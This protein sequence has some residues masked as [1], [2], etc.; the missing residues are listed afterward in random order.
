VDDTA[1]GDLFAAVLGSQGRKKEKKKKKKAKKEKRERDA[2]SQG[3]ERSPRRSLPRSPGH[4]PPTLNDSPP[5]DV[6]A[7]FSLAAAVGLTPPTS[8]ASTAAAPRYQQ[9]PPRPPMVNSM[10]V[11][12][13]SP[14]ETVIDG[15]GARRSFLDKATAHSRRSTTPAERLQARR[16]NFTTPPPPPPLPATTNPATVALPSLV[17]EWENTEQQMPV[18][19]EMS[20]SAE[21]TAA[22]ASTIRLA[23][24]LKARRRAEVAMAAAQASAPPPDEDEPPRPPMVNTMT[25]PAASPEETVISSAGSTY[26]SGGG[27]YLPPATL[28]GSGRGFQSAFRGVENVPSSQVDSIAVVDLLSPT[29]GGQLS[30]S[31][32]PLAGGMSFNQTGASLGASVTGSALQGNATTVD[33]TATGDLFAAVLGSQG[34]KKEKKK[35]KKAKKEKR[36]RSA[37]RSPGGGGGERS[38]MDGRFEVEDR[39]R[40]FFGAS[41]PRSPGP[42]SSTALA[43][44]PVEAEHTRRARAA[45]VG[46]AA[47]S[48]PEEEGDAADDLLA[49]AMEP[50]FD[51]TI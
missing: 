23:A 13:T 45:T 3:S 17:T 39:G 12:A 22:V 15:G 27:S 32:S 31:A 1:T 46:A 18:S 26:S 48:P 20:P 16:R 50:D 7:A 19:P 30:A 44:G 24:H 40:V 47:A 38:P 42:P 34:R 43:R 2:M 28:H 25:V 8:A 11:P 4:L 36:E 29:A 35:K 37:P 10:T 21:T 49:V 41:P 9:D 14:E 6:D 33:D 5:G 51:A